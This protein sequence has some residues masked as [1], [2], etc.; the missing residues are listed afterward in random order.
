MFLRR[1]WRY[2]FGEPKFRP[3]E[4][5]PFT[6]DEFGRLLLSTD[7]KDRERLVLTLANH[8]GRRPVT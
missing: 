7:P 8:L 3:N 4:T 1:I 2:L 6:P 5:L